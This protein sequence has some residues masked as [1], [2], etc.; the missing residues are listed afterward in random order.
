MGIVMKFRTLPEVDKK[1]SIKKSHLEFVAVS[2]RF[3]DF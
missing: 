1:D 3:I 2:K